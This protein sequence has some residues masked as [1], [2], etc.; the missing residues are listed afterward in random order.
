[1]L[2]P[3]EKLQRFIQL[4]INRGY[5]NRAV[6]GGLDKFQSIWQ[7]EASGASIPKNVIETVSFFLCSYG[8]V[9]INQR[10]QSIQ[11]MISSIGRMPESLIKK[12]DLNTKHNKTIRTNY[13]SLEQPEN[14][15]IQNSGSLQKAERKTANE[16]SVVI[17]NDENLAICNQRLKSLL[18]ILHLE[19]EKCIESASDLRATLL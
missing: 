11:D 3:I 12:S 19:S 1:M 9:D 6:V 14:P 18:A 5:D 10:E 7:K 4:E 13:A 15:M 8:S 17:E 16:R 2:S